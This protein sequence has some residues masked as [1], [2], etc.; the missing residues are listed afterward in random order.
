MKKKKDM[1]VSE[2]HNSF[3]RILVILVL[4]LLYLISI[5]DNKVSDEISTNHKPL[6]VNPNDVLNVSVVKGQIDDI[7][8]TNKVLDPICHCRYISP[9]N[10]Q[11]KGIYSALLY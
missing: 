2:N 5:F 9:P 4:F 3:I 1:E 8:S 7:V 6:P 10:N 11:S